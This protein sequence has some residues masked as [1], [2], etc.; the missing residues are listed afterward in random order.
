M[1]ISLQRSRTF[2]LLGTAS[3]ILGSAAAAMPPFGSWSAPANLETLPSSSQ[4]INTPAVDGC[5]SLSRDGLTL[6][7]NSNRTGNFDLYVAQRSSKS[8]GFGEPQRLPA[9]VNT[10]A[11]E[12]CATFGPGNSLYFASDRQ[13]PAYDLYVTRRGPDG[14]STPQNLGPNVNRPGYLEESAAFYE[15]EDGHQVMLFGSRLPNGSDGKIYQS[16]DGGPATLVAGGPHSSANDDRPSV[17]HD[18]LTIFFDSDRFGTLGG[19]DLYYSTRSNTH[20]PFGPAIHLESLSSPVFDARPFISWDGTMLTFSS[21]RPGGSS[22]AP[23]M[24]FSTRAKAV[25]QQ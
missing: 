19:P 13:D 10:S 14:W 4:N 8:E 21:T 1:S 20:E 3:L 7:F 17:T 11:N 2:A 6:V 12:S 16:V 9:P 15:D 5:D 22:P 24:W 23:D 25:G 18:G